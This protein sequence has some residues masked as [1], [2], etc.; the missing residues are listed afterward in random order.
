MNDYY[1]N[2]YS[3]IKN[4]EL[5]SV[6]RSVK[7][8]IATNYSSGNHGDVNKWLA[9]LSQIPEIT[10]S[11]INLD[12]AQI[13]IGN[14]SDCDDEQRNSLSKL[15]LEFQPW[16]KGP[17]KLFG[18]NLDAEWRSDWKWDRLKNEIAPLNDKTV[19]DVGCGN[20]Y[21]SLRML[22]AGAKHVIGIDPTLLY[23]SQFMVLNHFIKTDSAHVLPLSLEDLPENQPVF[24]T[25]FSMGVLYH[26][27]SPLEHLARLHGYIRVD[28]ELVLETLIIDGETQTVL[29]PEGRYAK[30]RNVWQIPTVKT[31]ENWLE[32]VGF[33]NIR[34]IDVTITTTEEQRC[35]DW[36]KFESLENFL[37]PTDSTRTI[38]GLPAPRRALMIAKK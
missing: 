34:L 27:K 11:G 31:L 38:E 14:K 36:M 33:Q 6:F 1:Y 3:T 10:F 13:I 16:R 37:D 19:L 23:V 5:E 35:T 8:K 12:Q 7:E 22:G 29:E 26:R 20:G 21:Y 15:L 9:L 28:G 32:S 24:D 25:V 4:T 2:F 30:M 18:I 17:F